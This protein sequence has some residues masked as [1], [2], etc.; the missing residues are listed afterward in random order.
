[1]ID[2]YTAIAILMH[3]LDAELPILLMALDRIPFYIGAL[4]SRTTHARRVAALIDLGYRE[5]DVARIKAPIGIFDKATSSTSLAVSVVADV[6]AARTAS[7][8]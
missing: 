8:P 6:V 1:M 4:G 2:T 7:R 3:D 5:A